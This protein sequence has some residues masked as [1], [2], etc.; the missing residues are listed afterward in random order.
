MMLEH[1]GEGLIVFAG[2]WRFVF[3]RVYRARKLEEWRAAC[4]TVGGKASIAI[5]ILAAVVLGVLLPIWLV[6]LA[7]CRVLRG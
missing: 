2:F 3:S 4:H 6:V 5:E 7:S 1:A